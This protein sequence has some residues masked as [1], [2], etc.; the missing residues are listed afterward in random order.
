MW[1]DKLR[2]EVEMGN[3]PTEVEGEE[4]SGEVA[5]RSVLGGP[6]LLWP[7]SLVHARNPGKFAPP[8]F[9]SRLPGEQCNVLTPALVSRPPRCF[10]TKYGTGWTRV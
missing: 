5:D 9:T 6:L 7:T 3:E 8:R 2:F 1:E 4:G 10:S